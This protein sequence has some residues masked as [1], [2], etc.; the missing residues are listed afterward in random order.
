VASELDSNSDFTAR[1]LEPTLIHHDAT[2][3]EV[4][5]GSS[6][7]ILLDSAQR[8]KET[9]KFQAQI[10]GDFRLGTLLGQGGMGAVYRGRQISLDR[11]VAIKVLPEAVSR[12][13]VFRARFIRESKSVATI[14]SPHV[15]QVIHAGSQAGH[16]FYVM[17]LVKGTDLAR[18]LRSSWRP[19]RAE[20]LDLMTQAARGLAAA[21]KHGIIHRDIKPANMLLGED[22][23]LKLT[24]FG[25]AR[26]RGANDQQLTAAGTVMGTV[27][28]LSP[29]QAMGEDCD[30]R[31][32]L[33]SL[34]VV[35]FELLTGRVPYISA[36]AEGTIY[37]HL[38]EPVPDPRRFSPRVDAGCAAV[39]MR[40]LAKKPADRY[41]DPDE[42]LAD[43]DRLSHQQRPLAQRDSKRR[44]VVL[45]SVG[46]GLLVLLA[47][48]G[49]LLLRGRGPEAA[50]QVLAPAPAPTTG[51]LTPVVATPPAVPQPIAL[52]TP[53]V[54]PQPGTAPAAATGTPPLA[55][56]PT[57]I[58]AGSNQI[59]ND[60][61]GRY[62]DLR[63]NQVV[64]RLREC[65]GGTFTM[66]SPADEAG[67]SRNEL[68]HQVTLASFWI[69]ETEVTQAEWSAVM[70]QN[71][72]QLVAADHP[73]ENLSREQAM[74]YLDKLSAVNPGLV[75]RLPTE[76]EWE[77][78]CRA[79]S[80]AA[81]SGGRPLNAQGWYNENSGNQTH[82]AKQFLPNA[83]GIFDLHGN[84]W[85]W[86]A[87]G[88]ADYP[89]KAVTQPTPITTGP[90]AIRGG[91]Y[92]DTLSDCRCARRD[93]ATKPSASIG[94]RFVAAR[95]PDAWK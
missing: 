38:H 45:A 63:L 94:F 58:S 51:T 76:A 17:E 85:E 59:G 32:D 90:P 18:K 93:Y 46:G 10:W 44:V 70:P 13:E 49:A 82:A 54:S 71:P 29:E 50:P 15:V 53:T 57:T 55:P 62:I 8:G 80:Q 3:S 87:D 21:H 36:D 7:T 65:P 19:T 67:R 60:S 77:Y 79:G 11:E 89:A 14:S 43:L 83:W 41:Q 88:L 47:V 72:S 39:A 5:H 1:S 91:S 25:L 22:G 27:T 40:L 2:G 28:Y 20:F 56:R 75:L 33:Y 16:E 23:T 68:P 37:Q 78:A 66:G 48:I 12:D 86:T 92:A 52:Q 64:L 24:D 84:V 74:T 73:V 34:G 9:G 42:L 35:F 6:P 30:Q 95:L 69:G 61:F 81:F 31:T 4:S 26:I